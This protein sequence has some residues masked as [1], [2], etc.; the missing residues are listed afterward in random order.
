VTLD[1]A[2]SEEL[3]NQSPSRATRRMVFVAAPGTEILDLVGPLQVFAR[4]VG[5]LR[6]GKSGRITNLFRSRRATSRQRVRMRSR[7]TRKNF[8]SRAAQTS[9]SRLMSRSGERD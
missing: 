2:T 7:S 5:N 1:D 9:T 4:G 6:Q 3:M 8:C